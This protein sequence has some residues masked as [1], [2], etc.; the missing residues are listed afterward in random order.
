VEKWLRECG[1]GDFEKMS[2]FQI[3]APESLAGA[4]RFLVEEPDL[5][6]QMGENGRRAFEKTYDWKFM[7][8][9]LAKLYE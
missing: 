9:R 8:E 4:L 6:R 5:A 1:G 3:G 2:G 7:T